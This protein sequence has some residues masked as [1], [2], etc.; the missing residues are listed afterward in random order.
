MKMTK[1]GPI[2]YSA[3]SS[4]Y[5]ILRFSLEPVLDCE[6]PGHGPKLKARVFWDYNAYDDARFLTSCRGLDSKSSDTV[7]GEIIGPNGPKLHIHEY[8]LMDED[9]YANA[10]KWLMGE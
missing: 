9:V 8:A 3:I 5:E 10:I 6:W 1:W 4:D 2:V 7:G